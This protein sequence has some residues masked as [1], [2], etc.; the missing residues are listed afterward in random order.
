LR[1]LHGILVA[2]CTA[3]VLVVLSTVSGAKEPLYSTSSGTV[4]QKWT[5]LGTLAKAVRN[6]GSD[7]VLFY[8]RAGSPVKR[9]P[10]SRTLVSIAFDGI[11]TVSDST[12]NYDIQKEP[13]DIW[14]TPKGGVYFIQSGIKLFG[15]KE[16]KGIAVYYLSPERDRLIR[17]VDDLEAPVTLIGASDGSTLNIIL[18]K[19]ED[20]MLYK[21]A[22]DGSLF[23]GINFVPENCKRC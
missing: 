15:E 8:D 14:V 16:P 9:A 3:L 23:D 21:I 18:K 10:I 22:P 4:V 19:V 17:V 1:I 13:H 6:A 2:S 7:K 20:S 5:K 11:V 12:Y